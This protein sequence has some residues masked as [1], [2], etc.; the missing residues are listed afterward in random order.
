MNDANEFTQLLTCIGFDALNQR[1]EI[2]NQGITTCDD[3]ADL[4]EEELKG[5]YEEN[6]NANRRR[7]S[8]NQIV[9]PILAKARLEAIRYE[10]ELRTMCHKPM[11]L[12]QIQGVTLNVAKTFVKQ[13][14]QREEGIENASKLPTP[15]VPKLEKGNWRAVRDSFIELLSRET[16]AKEE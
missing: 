13:K 10:L 4:S 6:K 14:K 5:V 2:T 9:L 7:Q 15:D 3:L 1:E 11:S 16:G 12:A 8:N